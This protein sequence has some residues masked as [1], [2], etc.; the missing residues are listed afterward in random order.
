[1]GTL[2][3]GAH[4][5]HA[6]A[7]TTERVASLEPN[8]IPEPWPDIRKFL[9]AGYRYPGGVLVQWDEPIPPAIHEEIIEIAV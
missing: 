2:R 5:E 6:A 1:M 4:W 7:S 3:L 8:G 9:P